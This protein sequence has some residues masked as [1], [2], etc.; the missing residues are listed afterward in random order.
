MRNCFT[1][2]PKEGNLNIKSQTYFLKTTLFFKET[3]T[4][5]LVHCFIF[6]KET[7]TSQL[8][9]CFAIVVFLA[10]NNVRKSQSNND[11]CCLKVATVAIGR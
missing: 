11:R 6:F 4:S 10:F 3:S 1:P 7:S 2:I 5:Q 8:V 9:H